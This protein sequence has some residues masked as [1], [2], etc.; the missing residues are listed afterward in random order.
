MIKIWHFC[1][2]IRTIIFFKKWL[3]F[4]PLLTRMV[5]ILPFRVIFLVSFSLCCL[6]PLILELQYNWK[7]NDHLFDLKYWPHFLSNFTCQSILIQRM[8]E[9]RETVLK[10]NRHEPWPHGTQSFYICKLHVQCI[11]TLNYFST[12][13]KG[14]LSSELLRVSLNVGYLS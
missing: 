1:S 3:F 14:V 7:N 6:F 5:K 9:P 8:L 2:I 10:K 13:W 12:W 11:L 4:L